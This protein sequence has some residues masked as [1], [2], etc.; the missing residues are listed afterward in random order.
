[1]LKLVSRV[2]TPDS[3]HP[4]S[5]GASPDSSR[6]ELASTDLSGRESIYQMRRFLGCLKP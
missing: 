3:G 5:P 4:H 2:M 1:M 6:S